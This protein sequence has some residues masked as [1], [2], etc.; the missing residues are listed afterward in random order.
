MTE[1]KPTLSATSS[2]N[3]LSYNENR[4]SFSI[5]PIIPSLFYRNS[6]LNSPQ[7]S[8]GSKLLVKRKNLLEM[9][10]YP[11]GKPSI[12]KSISPDIESKSKK[13]SLTDFMGSRKS[14]FLKQSGFIDIDEICLKLRHKKMLETSGKNQNNAEL[15]KGK[16]LNKSI[17]RNQNANLMNT[18]QT[19]VK[20]KIDSG[21]KMTRI[22]NCEDIIKMCDEMHSHAKTQRAPS[23]LENR[24]PKRN[25]K[26][27]LSQIERNSIIREVYKL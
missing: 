1:L 27:R 19:M 18:K 20:E 26:K 22:Q 17:E 11:T 13:I 14:K 21:I 7:P 16:T 9:M 10:G 6:N 15:K 2:C 12:C 5:S 8:S 4:S 3:F 23:C 24:A 25:M